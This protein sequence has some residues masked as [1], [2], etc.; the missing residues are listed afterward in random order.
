MF[1]HWLTVSLVNKPDESLHTPLHD[2]AMYGHL[3]QVI[4]LMDRGVTF[5]SAYLPLRYA[6]ENGLGTA[7]QG[8]SVLRKSPYR[9][10]LDMLFCHLEH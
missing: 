8:I 3:K 4:L 1:P 6:C 7:K 2:A 5:S 9:S 10:L